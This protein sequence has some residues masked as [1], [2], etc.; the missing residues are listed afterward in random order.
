MTIG[1]IDVDVDDV[2]LEQLLAR[3]GQLKPTFSRAG[4]GCILLAVVLHSATVHEGKELKG[5]P[6]F[7]RAREDVVG[8]SLLA[9]DV[10]PGKVGLSNLTIGF[11]CPSDASSVSSGRVLQ[12]SRLLLPAM[13]PGEQGALGSVAQGADP[14]D[15]AEEGLGVNG[16]V[17]LPETSDLG[18]HEAVVRWVLLSARVP[19]IVNVSPLTSTCLVIQVHGSHL[20][21][22]RLV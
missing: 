19:V 9:T 14:T 22:Q 17:L 20:C 13:R 11:Y 8:D 15:R 6:G 21:P 7:G 12:R 4:L 1:G 16:D 2:L 5:Q 18:V 10:N 3:L